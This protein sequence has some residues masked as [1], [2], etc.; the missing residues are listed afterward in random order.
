M[1]SVNISTTLALRTR[2]GTLVAEAD[3]KL[4]INYWE[5]GTDG[6]WEWEVEA[7]HFDETPITSACWHRPSSDPELWPILMRAVD[8]D[9]KSIDEKVQEAVNF[10]NPAPSEASEHRKDYLARVL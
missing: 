6:L 1:P 9:F 3:C 7:V 8:A 2:H 10:N 5:C 4:V